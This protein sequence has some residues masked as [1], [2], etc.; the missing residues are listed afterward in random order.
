MPLIVDLATKIFHK[1]RA[2]LA[3]A[4]EFDRAHLAPVSALGAEIKRLDQEAARVIEWLGGYHKKLDAKQAKRNE[5][6]I[7]FL[8]HQEYI[9]RLGRDLVSV[10]RATPG[11]LATIDPFLAF[12]QWLAAYQLAKAEHVRGKILRR[13]VKLCGIIDR[14]SEK[15]EKDLAVFR[16]FD[17]KNGAHGGFLDD[18]VAR[19]VE[20]VELFGID[21]GGLRALNAVK[22]EEES[23][24]SDG[25]EG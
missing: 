25:S 13:F 17:A 5:L 14:L 16:G 23:E 1:A 11:N 15:K 24:K 4:G 21:D 9:G 12:Q 10:R 2:I 19:A 6:R 22:E 20:V 8:A 18:L 3:D 7:A